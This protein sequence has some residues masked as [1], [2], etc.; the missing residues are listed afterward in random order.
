MIRT[1]R[2]MMFASAAGVALLSAGEASAAIDSFNVAINDDGDLVG[3]F[4][5]AMPRT[6]RA[7]FTLRT[8]AGALYVCADPNFKPRP[9][10]K[11]RKSVEQELARDENFTSDYQGNVNGSFSVSPPTASLQCPIGYNVHLAWVK[12]STNRLSSSYG[13]AAGENVSREFISVQ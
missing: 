1:I 6:T 8:K 5:G 13:D 9:E 4:S 12:Y 3:T 10:P 7:T 2:S 11:Y